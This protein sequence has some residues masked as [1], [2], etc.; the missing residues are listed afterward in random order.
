MKSQFQFVTAIHGD[1]SLPVMALASA[2]IPQI[3]A[4]PRALSFG[5]RFVEKDLNASFG[6]QGKTYEEIRAK[7]LL[8][9]LDP[10]IPVVDFHTFSASSEPFVVV[11]DLALLSLAQVCG[12]SRIVYMHHNIKQGHAL[13]NYRKGVS[14]EVGHH[15]DFGSFEQAK[16]VCRRLM[17][18]SIPTTSTEV[19]EVYD[20]ITIPGR[21]TNFKPYRDQFIPVLAGEKAYH[22]Y[23]LKARKLE[24][25]YT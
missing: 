12:I 17:R 11:V 24:G 20:I 6:C 22:F 7:E 25:S 2:N 21:Y 4:N 23:G 9:V 8:R 1:E 13:I 19:F 18:G 15:T 16:E 3:V 14:I 10:R 5:R